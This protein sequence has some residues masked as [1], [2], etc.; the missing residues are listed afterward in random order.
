MEVVEEEEPEPVEGEEPEPRMSRSDFLEEPEG[1][2]T[3]R[4]EEIEDDYL[5]QQQIDEDEIAEV[6]EELEEALRTAAVVNLSGNALGRAVVPFW[7]HA[8]DLSCTRL[9]GLPASWRG[10]LSVSL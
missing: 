3:G 4:G 7:P 6:E 1:T 2:S 8:L 5:I 10:A 9:S